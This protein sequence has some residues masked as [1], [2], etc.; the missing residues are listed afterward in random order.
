MRCELVNT[1]FI[2]PKSKTLVERGSGLHLS[3][4]ISSLAN[5]SGLDGFGEHSGGPTLR[6]EVG[7]L[8]ED[9]LTLVLKERL[10]QRMGEI[11]RDGVI[12]SPDGVGWGDAWELAEY[13]ATWKSS[14]N[15][16][17][18][19]WR[20]MTQIRSYLAA[21]EADICNLFVLYVMGDYRDSGPQA[22][23]YRISFT[24]RE[25]EENWAMITRHARNKGWL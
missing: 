11:V 19:N 17:T 8:W 15:S 18:D 13:K 4:I 16:P 9:L 3:Q 7:F 12:M 24:Q 5:E 2:L 6:M 10:P 23:H 1:D 25:L 21:V 20:W 14:K 22:F